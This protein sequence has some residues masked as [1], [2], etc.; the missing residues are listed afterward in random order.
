MVSFDNDKELYASWTLLF[1]MVKI[2]S[3]NLTFVDSLYQTTKKV[4]DS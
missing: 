1:L 2:V 4:L 3:Y